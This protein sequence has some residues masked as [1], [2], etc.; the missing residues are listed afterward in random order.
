MKRSRTSS[1]LFVL[2][3]SSLTFSHFSLAAER[4]I[5]IAGEGQV[6]VLPDYLTFNI[7]IQAEAKTTPLAKQEVDKAMHYLLE[8]TEQNA[9]P[10]KDI[11]AANISNQPVYEWVN[12]E[13]KLRAQ[14]VQRTV[15]ITLRELE[16]HT[17]LLHQ[18]L[19][20]PNIQIQHTQG[21]FNDPFA[22]Q[23]KATALAL[24]QAKEKA[25]L[26]ATT[27]D[28]R[29]GKV[30]S[31]EEQGAPMRPMYSMRM[32]AMQSDSAPEAAPMLVQK[33]TISS[34]VQVRFELR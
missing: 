3:I 10:N 30:L 33:Q 4:F 17:E 6:E 9:I 5:N 1:A 22:L 29:L 18:L 15:V 12:N 11:E 23:M 25:N 21:H 31:I 14:Q 19:Q 20:Q 32:Q 26:M 7:V 13:R 28:T 27:L 34:T 2:L 8:T 16:R 24:E